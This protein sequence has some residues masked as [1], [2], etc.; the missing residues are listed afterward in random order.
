M[1]QYTAQN[2]RWHAEGRTKDGVLRHPA[3]RQ[4][5]KSFDNLH[6]DFSSDSRNIRL[7][8]ILDEFNPFG[9]MSTSHSTWP[10]MLVLYNLLPWMCMKQ[11][12]FIL[13]LVISGPKSPRMDID[14]YLQPLIEELQELWNVG[15]RTFNV[16]KRKH[17]M[18]RAQLMWTINDFPT[19]AD[20]SRW[21]TRGVKACSCCIY[22]TRSTWL[23]QGKKYCFMG[24]RR[25]LPV[26]HLF[27]KNRRTFAD[28][29]ELEC[30]PEVPSGEEI[31]RQLEGMIFGDESADKTPKP[32]L[33]TKKDR[34]KKKKKEENKSKK[35]RKRNNNKN[36]EEPVV[37]EVLWKKKKKN[38][39]RLP[40]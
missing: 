2:M 7:G 25:Y 39:F 5:W 13:S 36:Q 19:Y 21:L 35:K 11:S 8:L 14:V 23:K 9:N 1:S 18:M 22:S 37:A 17:F 38:F 28:K 16:S 29:Q 33:S 3:D 12:S 26:D 32:P 40:Y 4:A 6:P 27:R 20:L 30:A 24:H 15:V 31:L 34:E 10:V